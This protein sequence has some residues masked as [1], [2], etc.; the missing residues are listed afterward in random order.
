MKEGGLRQCSTKESRFFSRFFGKCLPSSPR[1][2]KSSRRNIEKGEQEAGCVNRSSK[3]CRRRG[4]GYEG[5]TL[6]F[7]ITSD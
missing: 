4:A 5:R 3:P 7:A 6:L 1:I 2:Y